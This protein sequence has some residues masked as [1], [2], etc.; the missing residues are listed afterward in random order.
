MYGVKV[1]DA[2]TLV[3]VVVLDSLVG[4]AAT[5]LSTMRIARVALGAALRA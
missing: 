2:A 4:L 3:S 1:F 5:A